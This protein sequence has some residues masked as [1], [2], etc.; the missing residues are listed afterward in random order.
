[1]RAKLLQM[2]CE[3]L[4]AGTHDSSIRRTC[5]THLIATALEILAAASGGAGGAEGRL[6]AAGGCLI[7]SLNDA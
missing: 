2:H 7:S 6:L 4:A 5:P 1:M 3:V